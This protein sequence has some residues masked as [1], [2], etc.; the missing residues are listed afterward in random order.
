VRVVFLADAEEDL[1][2]IRRYVVRKFGKSDWVDTSRK[3]R[4]SIRVIQTFPDGGSIPEELSGL[5]LA[6]FRQVISG[7]NRLIYEVGDGIVYIHIVC[8]TRRDLRSVL[9]RRLLRIIR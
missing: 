8:D 6:R 9:T 7:Q 4:D 2:D 1:K 3:I 5:S